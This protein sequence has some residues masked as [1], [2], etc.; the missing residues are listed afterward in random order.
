VLRLIEQFSEGF[1]NAPFRVNQVGLC[2]GLLSD[3][4]D[5]HEMTR[6]LFAAGILVLPAHYDPRAIEFRPILV[7]DEN[8]ADEIV[9]TV[10]DVLG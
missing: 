9:R 8:D 1:A 3:T 5:S 4:M 7:L 10:R 6:K 2:M